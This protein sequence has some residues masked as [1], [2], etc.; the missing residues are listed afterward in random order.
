MKL[1]Y[2]I[3]D[4]EPLAANVIKNHMKAFDDFEM[5]SFCHNAMEAFGYLK[6]NKVDVIFLDINMPEI[7]GIDILKSLKNPPLVVIT[8]AYR[9]YAVEGFELSVF[10]Y[11]VKPIAFPRF[12]KAIDKILKHFLTLHSTFASEVETGEFLFVKVDKKM[13]KILFE[14]IL[15]IESLKDYV[16]IVTG[17]E[18]FITHQNLGNFTDILPPAKFLRIHRS[19]TIALNKIKALDG[20]NIEIGTKNLPIGRN[21]QTDVK[22]KVLHL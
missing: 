12:V 4:D 5:A 11:L 20:N 2:L 14:D 10:D 15:Y 3:V 18:S 21:Y 8:T 6:N 16:K 17:A 1:N 7:S 19:Y 13:V 22:K 9:E